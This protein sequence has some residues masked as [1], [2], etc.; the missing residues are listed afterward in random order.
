MPQLQ[1]IF[2]TTALSDRPEYNVKDGD[3]ARC[4]EP[5]SHISYPSHSPSVITRISQPPFGEAQSIQ[6]TRAGCHIC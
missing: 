2:S 3:R 4:C 6:L 1:Q 5:P